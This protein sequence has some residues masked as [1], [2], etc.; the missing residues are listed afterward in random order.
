MAEQAIVEMVRFD[1]EMGAGTAPFANLLLRSESAAS[2]QIENLTA[3]SRKIALAG[4]GDTSSGNARLIMSN[5]AAMKAALDLSDDLSVQNIREMHRA[6]MLESEPDIAGQIRESQVWI[7]GSSPHT[8]DFVPPHHE[9]VT[10]ALED[11]AE[12][13]QRDDVPAL[14][15]SAIAH[16]QFE[17]I[18]PFADGNG[19]TGRA[20]VGSILRN[21]NVTERV[22]IPVS[23]GLLTDTA[24]Y[25][26]S[27]TAYREGDIQPIV[28]L[29]AES[30]FRA[31]DNGR[32]LGAEIEEARN[33]YKGRVMHSKSKVAHDVVD[34]LT[35][36]PAIT[37]QMLKHRTDASESAVYRA[38]EVLL[39]AEVL[40]PAGKVKGMAVYIA[41]DIIDALDDFA[42]RAGRRQRH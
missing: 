29:F 9:R 23:S 15:Q 32:Q 19:R 8:A 16:A 31:I 36:E 38:M 27:L 33:E 24:T 21:K 41:T 3:G 2:S 1:A 22:T 28:E 11:L 35:S 13:M 34:F 6:L 4:L 17:T 12:F 40:K 37:A 42:A 20:I 10:A 25:F 5:V 14:T 26:E 7:H 39:D 30:T 18:R